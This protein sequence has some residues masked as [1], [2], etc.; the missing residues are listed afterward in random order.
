M[1]HSDVVTVPSFLPPANFFRHVPTIPVDVPLKLR[2]AC[3]IPFPCRIAFNALAHTGVSACRAGP[4]CVRSRSG[5]YLPVLTPY[6]LIKR[7]WM[8]PSHRYKES[9]IQQVVEKLAPQLRFQIPDVEIEEAFAELSLSPPTRHVSSH[10][11]K[12]LVVEREKTMHALC[13]HLAKKYDNE[14]KPRDLIVALETAGHT[15][16]RSFRVALLEMLKEQNAERWAMAATLKK[17]TVRLVDGEEA[18][19]EA[20][21]RSYNMNSDSLASMLL[22]LFAVVTSTGKV[23]Y[24]EV[25]YLASSLTDR[26]LKRYAQSLNFTIKKTRKSRV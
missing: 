18:M 4:A 13:D 24:L 7:F 21:Q 19:W 5:Y 26:E 11:R 22:R 20:L 6:N 8:K 1:P 2:F 9:E 3:A 10:V 16:S 14:P 15:Y 23:D 17:R 25:P 12:L